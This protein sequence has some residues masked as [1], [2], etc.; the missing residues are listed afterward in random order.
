MLGTD[1]KFAM[2]GEEMR[3]L[4]HTRVQ[5]LADRHTVRQWKN[6]IETTK[7]IATHHVVSDPWYRSR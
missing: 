4:E 7:A 2:S 1:T 3:E 6:T 5:R